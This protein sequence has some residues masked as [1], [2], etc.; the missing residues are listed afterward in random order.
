MIAH[1]LAKSDGGKQVVVVVFQRHLHALAHGLQTGEM[2]GA[3]DVVL[4][5]YS[6]QRAAVP[7]VRLIERE[8]LARD[9]LHALHRLFTAVYKI[10]YYGH[11]V[12]VLQKKYA[13]V[14]AYISGSAGNK[15]CHAVIPFRLSV[16]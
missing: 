12:S 14:A 6:I 1:G 2:D 9:L 11:I 8:L 10:V 5:E 13:G 15:Y 4:G 7:D 16:P 3:A